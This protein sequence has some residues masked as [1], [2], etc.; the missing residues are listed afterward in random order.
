MEILL[1]TLNAIII[2]LLADWVIR[3]L[4]KRKGQEFGL[5]GFC[6][7]LFVAVGPHKFY[8]FDLCIMDMK[9]LTAGSSPNR[10]YTKI[11]PNGARMNI[12][13]T[14]YMRQNWSLMC[15]LYPW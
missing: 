6:S 11:A 8:M 1:F 3:T 9:L 4:E 7:S 10:P 14:A 2:Y 15:E 13:L 5:C 12:I